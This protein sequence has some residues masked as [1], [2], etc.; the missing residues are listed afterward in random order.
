MTL[1]IFKKLVK[2]FK[3]YELNH[4]SLTWRPVSKD[5]VDIQPK[6]RNMTEGTGRSGEENTSRLSL[7]YE[8][9]TKCFAMI[10]HS[11]FFILPITD[12]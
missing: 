3:L 10:Q 9:Q 11:R 4:P 2:L 7:P 12:S 6:N 1:L 8:M 5:L